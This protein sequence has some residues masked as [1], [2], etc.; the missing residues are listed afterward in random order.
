MSKGGGTGSQGPRRG[1]GGKAAA[2]ERKGVPSAAG[3]GASAA[4][5]LPNL[6]KVASPRGRCGR[7]ATKEVC[8][9]TRR[10]FLLGISAALICAPAIV[11]AQS[12]MPL[13]GM[14]L[15]AERYCFGFVERLYIHLH[16]PK[17]TA[18]QTAGLSVHEIAA[19]FNRRGSRTINGAS[20]NSEGVNFVINRDKLIR[21]EDLVARSVC[22]SFAACQ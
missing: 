16:L 17:I 14:V 6:G 21:H 7:S 12:L 5:N 2:Q 11:R 1:S 8:M 19:D 22:R 20:W 3:D 15:P 10:N 4:A 18:L 13:R 9:T